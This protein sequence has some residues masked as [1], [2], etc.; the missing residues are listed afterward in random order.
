MDACANG[1]WT[2]MQN[3]RQGFSDLNR[4]LVWDPSVILAHIH[5][6]HRT[7]TSCLRNSTSN[8]YLFQIPFLIMRSILLKGRCPSVK[9]KLYKASVFV[10]YSSRSRRLFIHDSHERWSSSSSSSWTLYASST[11]PAMYV[12]MS[13][14]RWGVILTGTSIS[15]RLIP[16]YARS[17]VLYR[18]SESG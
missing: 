18:P 16:N 2:F 13:C 12:D 17:N 1:P 11:T 15:N 5:I 7:L 10:F 9:C 14:A 4:W 8:T 3:M 6:L